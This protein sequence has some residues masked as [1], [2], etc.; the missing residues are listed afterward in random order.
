MFAAEI[1][2]APMIDLHNLET[3]E[4]LLTLDRF[5]NHEFM[6]GTEAVKI[7]HG[8]GT[9]KL[10]DTVHAFLRN[11]DLVAKFRDA[12]APSQ[13]GGVTVAALYSK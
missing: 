6:E 3:H 8:R 10:R 7:I 9:G 5:I 4:A 2:S 1:G 11:H 13:Q 12:Q